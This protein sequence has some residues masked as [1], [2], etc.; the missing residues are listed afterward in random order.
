MALLTTTGSA[1]AATNSLT[2]ATYDRTGAKVSTGLTVVNVATNEEYK[3]TGNK[4]RW[5]LPKGIYAIVGDIWTSRDQSDTM[6]ARVV[7]VS[8][9]TK[10]TLDARWGKPLT[11]NLDK[12]PGPAFNQTLNAF[13]CV[14]PD[15]FG[16][17][18]AWNKPGKLY[19]IPHNSKYLRFA[20]SSD[21][22]NQQDA[23][24]NEAYVVAGSATTVPTTLTHTFHTASLATITNYVRSGPSAG[25]S[26][27][28]RMTASGACQDG[29]SITMYSGEMPAVA[30]VHAMAGTWTVDTD[31]SAVQKNGE[32][33]FIGFLPRT[34]KLVGG[35]STAQALLS[36]AWGPARELPAVG[37][38]SI[39]F[40]TSSMFTD[41]SAGTWGSE[42]SERSLVTLYG[43]DN[44]V[45]RS[46]WRTDWRDGDPYF[47]A[48]VTKNG[49]YTLKVNGQR[50]RPDQAYPSTMLSTRADATF[51]MYVT[52]K[53]PA[54]V[55]D[56]IIPQLIPL[57]LSLTNSA[58]PGTKTTVQIRPDR[59]YPGPDLR[60]G[61]VT[62][63]SATLLSSS[64]GG[65]T[66]RSAAVRKVGSSWLAD[67]TNPGQAGYVSLRARLLATNGQWVEVT[68]TRAYRVS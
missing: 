17:T 47:S 11:V 27:G 26:V 56:V 43:P 15:S 7:T 5:V 22:Q 39:G 9:T 30:K 23:L 12:A 6:S 65:K 28:V 36:S 4:T 34:V 33:A 46:L 14:G 35:K 50:W 53:A 24:H 38:G 20:Y 66:W 29:N 52:A 63:K 13:I 62:G 67:V 45:I 59:R 58:K 37:N 49:W 57:G 55:A 41:P 61:S 2:V 21:W 16:R 18:G 64:D 40:M 8:G 31:W 32:Q 10:T 19:V 48:K 68:I 51:R 3:G 54:R 25:D 42:G 1:S 60:F 44:K